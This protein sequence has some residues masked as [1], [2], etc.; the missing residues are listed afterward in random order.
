MF[1]K[2]VWKYLLDHQEHFLGK[3][4]PNNQLIANIFGD[5]GGH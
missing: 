2:I 5:Q 1:A 4:N 3:V